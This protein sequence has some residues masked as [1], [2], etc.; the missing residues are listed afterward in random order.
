MSKSKSMGM[1]IQQLRQIYELTPVDEQESEPENN[2]QHYSKKSLTY[3]LLFTLTVRI[4][5][6]INKICLNNNIL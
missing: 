1:N 5:K 2:T 3:H 4:K 6:K